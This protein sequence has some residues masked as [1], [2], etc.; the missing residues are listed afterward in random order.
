MIAHIDLQTAIYSAL[1]KGDWEV[2]ET[3]PPKTDMPYITIGDTNQINDNTKTSKRKIFNLVIHTWSKSTDSTVSKQLDD[4]VQV[5]LLDN[6]LKLSSHDLD[7]V[8]LEMLIGQREI[9]TDSTIFHSSL[10]F[11]FQITQK[12]DY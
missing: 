10:E 2:F 3:V 6:D 11:E 1:S 12:G 4:F 5:Q 8:S 9:T 7:M